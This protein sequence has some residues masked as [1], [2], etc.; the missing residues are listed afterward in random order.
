MTLV[1]I[2]PSHIGLSH[3]GLSVCEVKISE[4]AKIVEKGDNMQI[5]VFATEEQ[6]LIFPQCF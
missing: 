3:F 5:E 4:L 6:M 1:Q 2:T